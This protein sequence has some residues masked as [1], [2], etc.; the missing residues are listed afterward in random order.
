MAEGGGEFGYEDPDLDNL[1]DQDDDDTYEEQEV[2]KTQSF[3]P[4][5]ASSPYHRVETMEMKTSQH[6]QTGLPESYVRVT[7]EELR[8]RLDNLKNPA[9]GV[10]GDSGIPLVAH[11]LRH[12]EIERVRKFIKARYPNVKVGNLVIRFSDKNQI[13][14]LGPKQGETKIVLDNGSGFRKD[15]LSKTFVKK[16]LGDSAEEII[17]KNTASIREKQKEFEESRKQKALAEQRLLEQNEMV[18]SLNER[19]NKEKAKIDKLKDLPEYE[20]EIKRKKKLTNN[21]EKDLKEAIKERKEREKK[22]NWPIKM[23]RTSALKQVLQKRSKTQMLSKI[24]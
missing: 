4:G 17:R 9:T 6:E 15:F 18:M 1:L 24:V 10:L 5:A 19:L 16:I 22:V 11:D 8:R 13:V 14:V 7:D 2:D 3:Q 21:L 20:E 12:E 23:K